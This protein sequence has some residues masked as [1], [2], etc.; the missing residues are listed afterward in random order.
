MDYLIIGALVGSFAVMVTAHVAIAVG[1]V[2]EKPRWHGLLALVVCP[3]APFWGMQA[4]MRVRSGLWIGAL[5]VYV[6]ARIAVG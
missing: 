2:L 6:I 5:M 4:G 1:L 3:L